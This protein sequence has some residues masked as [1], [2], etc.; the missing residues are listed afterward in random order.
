MPPAAPGPVKVRRRPYKF[1]DERKRAYLDL[2]R[3]GG[4]RHASARSIGISPWT[5]VNRM[6]ADPKFAAEVERAEMEANEQVENALYEA[7]LSG[8]VVAIQVWLYNRMRERWAD[9]RSPL[10]VA[11]A[12]VI[13][14]HERLQ[15]LPDDELYEVIEGIY[16]RET[17]EEP[18][19]FAEG[20]PS[21]E[22]PPAL[23]PGPPP[24]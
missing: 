8:N 10:A 14:G 16:R 7:A 11:Q 24:E 6:N 3:A 22:P 13:S 1:T 21:S 2:L 9:R 17:G 20:S 15:E 5:V 18:P 19:I 23:T 4:R 12:A